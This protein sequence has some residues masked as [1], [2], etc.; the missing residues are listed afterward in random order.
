MLFW[1]SG[2][3]ITIYFWSNHMFP[4][5]SWGCFGLGRSSHIFV[6]HVTH[7]FYLNH[8]IFILH[9]FLLIIRNTF[10]HILICMLDK[11][12]KTM[13]LVLHSNQK[14]FLPP[15]TRSS[16]FKKKTI[17]LWGYFVNTMDWIILVQAIRGVL[18]VPIIIQC[19]WKIPIKVY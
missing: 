4:I 8:F 13:I 16:N 9:H 14:I 12:I 10:S 19:K 1:F 5:L 7:V 18:L 3:R 17:P 15:K 6:T 2:F 11:F